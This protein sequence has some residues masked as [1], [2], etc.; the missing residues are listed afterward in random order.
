[1]ESRTMCLL[2]KHSTRRAS[3]LALRDDSLRWRFSSWKGGEG[4]EE[5]E[6]DWALSHREGRDAQTDTGVPANEGPLVGSGCF[7]MLVLLMI[8]RPEIPVTPPCVSVL[9]CHHWG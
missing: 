4:V 8:P 2:G 7:W 6:R 1:M 5:M 9:A 3:S